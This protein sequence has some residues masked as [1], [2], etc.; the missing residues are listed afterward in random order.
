MAI[1]IGHC[2]YCTAIPKLD[3]SFRL[4]FSCTLKCE[5]FSTV[6][7]LKIQAEH[8]ITFDK[9]YSKCAWH[10]ISL[11]SANALAKPGIS[12]MLQAG[13]AARSSLA[14][15]D[16]FLTLILEQLSPLCWHSCFCNW[17][18]SLV[19]ELIL[20]N[21]KPFSFLL[22]KFSAGLISSH[23]CSS[24]AFHCFQ[25]NLGSVVCLRFWNGMWMSF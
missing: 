12:W 14:F 25:W 15:P 23:L 5:F 13:T 22:S 11:F 20:Q 1:A 17:L 10:T 18:V 8:L 16:S 21:T 24:T 6:A 19:G 2:H 7:V 3:G 9:W 4:V